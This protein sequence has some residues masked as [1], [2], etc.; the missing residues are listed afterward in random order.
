M[1]ATYLMTALEKHYHLQMWS[2]IIAPYLLSV[3]VL[4]LTR[5]LGAKRALNATPDDDTNKKI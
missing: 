5:Y 3:L 1:L 2:I 4:L